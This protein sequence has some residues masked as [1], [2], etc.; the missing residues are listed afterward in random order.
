[1][2]D[3]MKSDVP[4]FFKKGWFVIVGF[5]LL[6][7][8]AGYGIYISRSMTITKVEVIEDSDL[9]A[10]AKQDNQFADKS[11][12]EI[13]K[14]VNK[15]N[16]NA[17]SVI[18]KSTSEEI[19][20]EHFNKGLKYSFDKKYD[21]AIKEFQEALKINP[22]LPEA[23]SNMGFAYFDKGDID[24]AIDQQKK[25]IEILPDFANAYYGLALAYEKKGIIDEAVKDWN[26]YLEFSPVESL[27]TKKA[28]DR[29]E[30]LKKI[31][32]MKK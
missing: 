8:I 31:Q 32:K 16:P 9:S 17:K 2:N 5:I 28:K 1:M 3:N 13:H 18:K 25:A 26:K 14:N 24:K 23:Y 19:L 6:I 20:N 30:K 10:P 11:F 12:A 27:W 4:P 15:F 29:L 21:E 7:L 22:K